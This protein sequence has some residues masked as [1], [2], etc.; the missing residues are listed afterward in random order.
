[1]MRR[2]A[3][4]RGA[5]GLAYGLAGRRPAGA[6]PPSAI[7]DELVV[8]TPVSAFIVEAM[9]K[10][11]AAYAK[12]RWQVTLKTRAQRA[13]TPVSYERI[14]AW[15]G[16]PEADIFWGGEPALFQS[17]AEQKLLTR[18]ETPA[19]TWD[20]I[21]G[22]IGAPKAIP[23]KDPGRQWVGTALEVYGIAYN[24]RLLKRLGVPEPRDW[25]DVLHP[26][27]KGS[28]AQCTPYRSSSSH[29]TYEVILQS[30]GEA[31]GWEWLKRLAANTGAFVA[32][33]R[34]VPA[35]V[36]KGEYAV[37]F[38]VPSYFVFEEKLAGFDIKFLAP[39]R[40]FV[41]PEP[42]AI[43]AGARRPRAAR[44]FLGFLLSER[45]Q[46]LFMERGLFPVMPRYK[47]HGPPGST[48]ELAVQL[49]GGIRSFFEPPVTNVYDDEVARAR[50]REVNERFKRDIES[51]WSGGKGR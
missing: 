6:Q 26:K 17:L 15:K 38:G 3:F 7:E 36:A 1:M 47:V 11:F 28:V 9:L 24:P 49:T 48:V 31:E 35:V 22:S 45:G 41:T 40:A 19:E 5:A 51:S 13:G 23:L 37:G 39:K 43:L 12:E 44:E 27:L 18:L 34:D 50:F 21:P 16:Q 30:R 10:E 20:A 14:I 4:L 29:A 8:Q 32:A 33:S 42:F 46:R 25:D 2:R